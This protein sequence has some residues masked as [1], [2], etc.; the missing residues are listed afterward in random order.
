MRRA[1]LPGVLKGMALARAYAQMDAGDG[2]LR[3]VRS[4]PFRRE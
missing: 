3:L 1:E 2:G 4:G